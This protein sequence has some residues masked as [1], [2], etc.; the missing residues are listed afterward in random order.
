MVR[1]T[2]VCRK[3]L[4]ACHED[5]TLAFLLMIKQPVP[6]PCSVAPQNTAR[7]CFH[8]VCVSHINAVSL[9]TLALP[10]HHEFSLSVFFVSYFWVTV[11]WTMSQEALSTRDVSLLLTPSLSISVFYSHSSTTSCYFVLF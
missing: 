5:Y 7:A 4:K 11:I 6:S 1:L 3:R 10:H 2:L 8:I 9:F